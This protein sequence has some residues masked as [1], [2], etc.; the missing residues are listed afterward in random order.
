MNVYLC[1]LPRWLEHEH[2]TK[3]NRGNTT[4]QLTYKVV[5]TIVPKKYSALPPYWGQYMVR[6]GKRT[7]VLS[8]SELFV[9]FFCDRVKHN[10][11]L[12]FHG[13]SYMFA[14]KT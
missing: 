7:K 6:G 13:V 3:Y 1:P 8:S 12:R 11:C 9:A 4:N 2:A 5:M 10:I 14:Q